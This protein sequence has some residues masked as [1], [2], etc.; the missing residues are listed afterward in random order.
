M[1]KKDTFSIRYV[2]SGIW[3]VLIIQSTIASVFA[4]KTISYSQFMNALQEGKI[5]EIAVSQDQIQGKMKVAEGKSKE[6]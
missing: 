3:V 5:T 2:M 1:K 4:V 6:F